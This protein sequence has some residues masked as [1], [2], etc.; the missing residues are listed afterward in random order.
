[1]CH[2]DVHVRE[3]PLRLPVASSTEVGRVHRSV[4]PLESPTLRR[5]STQAAWFRPQGRLPLSRCVVTAMRHGPLRPVVPVG[6]QLGRRGRALWALPLRRP[7]EAHQTCGSN[8]GRRPR[9]QD[10]GRRQMRHD[11][12]EMA[13]KGESRLLWLDRHRRSEGRCLYQ[14]LACPRKQRSESQERRPRSS[15]KRAI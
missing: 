3:M 12:Q 5:G 14:P 2:Q 6:V 15:R 8:L 1:M 13:G 10:H 7:S 9:A 4:A 11:P